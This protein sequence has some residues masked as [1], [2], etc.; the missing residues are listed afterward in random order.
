[1][2]KPKGL[3][4]C[5][6]S[7]NVENLQDTYVKIRKKQ[8]APENG[9]QSLPRWRFYRLLQ[10]IDQDETVSRSFDFNK[11]LAAVQNEHRKSENSKSSNSSTSANTSPATLQFNNHVSLPN[12]IR[13]SN[14]LTHTLIPQAPAPN[15]PLNRPKRTLDTQLTYVRHHPIAV[16]NNLMP[17]ASTSHEDQTP[18]SSKEPRLSAP[19]GVLTNGLSVHEDEYVAFCKCLGVF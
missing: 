13:H 12:G 3:E 6:S 11:E 5:L 4:F 9:N 8:P 18:N 15:Q 7:I 10:F 2:E 1:V 16:Q 14:L 19:N 17:T